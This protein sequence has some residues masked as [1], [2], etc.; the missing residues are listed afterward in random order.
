[1]IHVFFKNGIQIQKRGWLDEQKYYFSTCNHFNDSLLILQYEVGY[2]KILKI[3]SF[4]SGF[5]QC[6]EIIEY[7]R[8]ERINEEEGMNKKLTDNTVRKDKECEAVKSVVF[9]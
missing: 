1:M 7:Q 6:K 2:E 5:Y 3:M 9:V 8:Q 4:Q